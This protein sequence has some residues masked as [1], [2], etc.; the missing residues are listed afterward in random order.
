MKTNRLALVS[1]IVGLALPAPAALQF[2]II[3]TNP[4][5]SSLT[6]A[7]YDGNSTFLAVGANSTT[8]ACTYNINLQMLKWTNSSVGG[9]VSLLSA[10]YGA[11]E[12]LAGGPSAAVFATTNGVNW[13]QKNNAFPNAAAV[14]ALGFNSGSGGRFAAAGSIVEIFW[15]GPGLSW[16]SAHLPSASFL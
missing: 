12:F 6:A 4:V 11:G 16:S 15:A 5:S 8:L 3:N 13:V 2:T 9:A 14:N 1:V 7:A 10:T